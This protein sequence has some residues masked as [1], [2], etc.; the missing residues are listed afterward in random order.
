MTSTEQNKFTPMLYSHPTLT[1]L[2]ADASKRFLREYEI[3]E[4]SQPE[5]ARVPMGRLISTS[6]LRE[7]RR[8]VEHVSVDS[9]NK[10]LTAALQKCFGPPSVRASLSRFQD[11]TGKKK[12]STLQ[13]VVK[14]ICDFADEWEAVSKDIRP[15][16]SLVIKTFLNGLDEQTQTQVKIDEAKSLNEVFKS[17]R[18]FVRQ[19]QSDLESYGVGLGS[20]GQLNLI[21]RPSG[22]ESAPNVTEA[23]G[24]PKGSVKSHG[25]AHNKQKVDK[26][27]A[28][29]EKAGSDNGSDPHQGGKGTSKPK[30]N[31][32]EKVR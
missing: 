13:E 16:E 7:L 30:P 24:K 22:G 28:K 10:V 21:K 9:S 12:R 5:M 17:V 14:L 32:S 31:Q 4:L 11:L 3:Y 26:R 15:P 1:E 25:K 18:T 29:T 23:S 2:S 6:V 19:R 8:E 27:S 20:N